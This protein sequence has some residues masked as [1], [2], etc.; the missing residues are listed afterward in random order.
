MPVACRTEIKIEARII[1]KL[2]IEGDLHALSPLEPF[3]KD[4]EW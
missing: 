1:G 2:R 4:V 3:R